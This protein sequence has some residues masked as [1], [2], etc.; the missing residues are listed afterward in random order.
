MKRIRLTLA[1]RILIA[2]A[3]ICALYLIASYRGIIP[4]GDDPFFSADMIENAGKPLEL[5]IGFTDIN[6][7]A[8]V[9]AANGGLATTADS[10]IGKRGVSCALTL[11]KDEHDAESAFLAGTV[12]ALATTPARFAASYHSLE[13]KSPAVFLLT[14][15]STVDCAVISRKPL[16]GSSALKGKSVICAERGESHIFGLFLA[17]CAKVKTGEIDWKFTNSDE[18]TAQ[19]FRK[20]K[21]DVAIIDFTKIKTSGDLPEP[22]IRSSEFAGLFRSVLIIREGLAA[23]HEHALASFIDGVFEAR[24]RVALMKLPD[25]AALYSGL[26]I[27]NALFEK[28]NPASL[29]AGYRE[30][31]DYFRITAD[32]KWDFCR[33]FELIRALDDSDLPIADETVNTIPLASVTTQTSPKVSTYELPH[34]GGTFALFESGISFSENGSVTDDSRF[35]LKSAAF[36]AAMSPSSAIIVGIGKNDS[37]YTASVRDQSVRNML[38]KEYNAPAKIILPA[39]DNRQTVTVQLIPQGG[40]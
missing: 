17:E 19:L 13:E 7:V 25:A 23:I 24:S 1:A 2:S 6:Q 4:D 32:R 11:F 34:N 28:I 36:F 38:T 5:R 40:K 9:V 21:G 33:E 30:N 22:V 35:A 12:N 14:G 8:S 20:G 39:K 26:G 16:A 10:P 29:S 3:A 27:R 37:S 31:A 18:E 15:S